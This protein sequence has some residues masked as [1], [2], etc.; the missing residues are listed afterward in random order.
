MASRAQGT[1]LWV[2]GAVDDINP[3]LPLRG[4]LLAPLRGSFKGSIGFF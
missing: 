4:S 1:S 2:R 3:R